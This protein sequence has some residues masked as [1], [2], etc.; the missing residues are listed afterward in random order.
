MPKPFG[1]LAL[2]VLV[3]AVTYGL[4]ISVGPWLIA[5]A[6]GLFL[7]ASATPLV[8]E[9][10]T[11]ERERR[12]WRRKQQ[13]EERAAFAKRTAELEADLGIGSREGRP[14]A[15]CPVCRHTCEHWEPGLPDRPGASG[16]ATPPL[17]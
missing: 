17:A 9:T 11:N 4:W 12:A 5:L 1:Y 3:T 13:A 6:L 2:I 10:V 8:V 16:S 15:Q 14:V 7:L